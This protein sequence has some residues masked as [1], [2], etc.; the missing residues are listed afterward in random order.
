MSEDEFV[1]LA[2][3]SNKPGVKG[4][5]RREQTVRLGPELK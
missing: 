4:G 5:K 1:D 3:S 2:E